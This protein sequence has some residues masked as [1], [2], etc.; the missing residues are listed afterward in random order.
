MFG[1]EIRV[2][3]RTVANLGLNQKQWFELMVQKHNM[4]GHG[5]L[6]GNSQK[7]LFSAKSL[8]CLLSCIAQNS[9]VSVALSEISP[10]I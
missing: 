3:S 5:G 4:T 6:V 7:N 9:H 10:Y 8:K 2:E 1:S